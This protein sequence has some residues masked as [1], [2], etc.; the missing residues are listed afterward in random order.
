MTLTQKIE[1]AM[2]AQGWSF[3]ERNGWKADFVYGTDAEIKPAYASCPDA[4][5]RKALT[6]RLLSV[7]PEGTVLV[8]E[9]G[10]E[11]KMARGYVRDA[12][13]KALVNF[14]DLLQAEDDG[15]RL[16]DSVT[17]KS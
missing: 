7:A 2:E 10:G 14:G 6:F 5:R 16:S 15:S 9:D 3:T 13:R 17:V 4:A 1:A 12:A 11:M 8:D